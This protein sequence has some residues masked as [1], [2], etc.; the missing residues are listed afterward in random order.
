MRRLQEAVLEAG[1]LVG[2]DLTTAIDGRLEVVATGGERDH[3]TRFES[4]LD[5][6]RS[7]SRRSSLAAA[8]IGRA[9]L[10]VGAGVVALV[11]LVDA[12]ARDAVATVVFG[13]ALVL[14]AAAAPVLSAVLAIND[15]LRTS[16]L[17]RPVVEL[18]ASPRRPEL[19]RDNGDAVDLAT[20]LARYGTSAQWH[21]IYYLGEKVCFTVN[22]TKT[23]G[24]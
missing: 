9:P 20:D 5:R 1:R 14:A 10:A 3:A 13:R 4:T 8:I 15:L 24:D 17:V 6:Y 12:T 11:A 2:A 22:Q 21:G 16:I 18:L 7:T 23:T 19:E